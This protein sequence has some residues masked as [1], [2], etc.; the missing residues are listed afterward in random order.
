MFYT[1]LTILVNHLYDNELD[2]TEI[3]PIVPA[4]SRSIWLVT[5]LVVALFVGVTVVLLTTANA[6]RNSRFEVTRQGLRLRGDLFGRLVPAATLRARE[7]RIVD[8]RAEADLAPRSRTMGTAVK[9]Y[10]AGWFRLRNGEKALL[11]LTNREQAVYIPTTDGY[12]LLLSPQRPE[13]FVARL[14]E[15][16]DGG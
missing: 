3:F 8:L 14:R 13:V 10:A 4:T 6:S 9:G 7:A 11:Y 2:M 16:T 15:V 5:L 12:S 1:P